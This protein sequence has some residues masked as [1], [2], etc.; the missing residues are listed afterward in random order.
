MAD[1]RKLGVLAAMALLL[2]VAGAAVFVIKSYVW[3]SGSENV[4]L[5]PPP[6]APTAATEPAAPAGG[7]ANAADIYLPRRR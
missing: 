7:Q 4:P 5:A 2:I 6:A 3:S 1:R